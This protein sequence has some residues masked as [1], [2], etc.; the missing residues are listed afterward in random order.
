[1]YPPC[2]AV[3]IF[4]IRVGV[5]H[6][7]GSFC[8]PAACLSGGKE[9]QG[10]YMRK[11]KTAEDNRTNYIYYF[12]DGSK[13][14]IT[15]GEN[16]E[17]TTIIS[18]LHAMDDAEVDADRREDYHCPVHYESYHDGDGDDADDRN[19]YLEDETY[20]PL[21]QILTSIAEEERSTR[22][23]KLKVALSELTDKQKDTV[24]KK[25]YRGMTNVDIAAE[26]GVSEAAI[27]NR[28]TKIYAT[29]KKK[30]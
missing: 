8:V 20:N 6:H 9:R 28:L 22:M 13:C 19:P 2:F 12:D 16:G 24:V 5:Y 18:Q 17:N 27:R 14:V 1:M 11:F 30:I 4:G 26:E 15:P 25:F 10:L 21:Q 7:I 29:L 23:V 3:P